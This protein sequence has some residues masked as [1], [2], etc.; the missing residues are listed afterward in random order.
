M[1]TERVKATIT[2]R[3]AFSTHHYPLLPDGQL[4]RGDPARRLAMFWL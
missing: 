4:C 2:G 3:V 1:S